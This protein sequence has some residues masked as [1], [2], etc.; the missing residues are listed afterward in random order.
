MYNLEM[1]YKKDLFVNSE[2]HLMAILKKSLTA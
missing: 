1:Q 2:T